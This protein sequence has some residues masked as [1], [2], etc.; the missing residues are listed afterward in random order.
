MTFFTSKRLVTAAFVLLVL[1]NTALLSILWQQ[2]NHRTET[3]HGV[4]QFD[5][6]HFF[7]GKLGLSELQSASFQKLR[8]QH[9]LKVRPEI[10]A[11]ALLKKQ[12]VEESLK[13][14]PDSK[15][16][17]SIIEGIGLHQ[18]AIER[19][20][21]LHFN[22][23]AKLCKPEQRKRLKDVLENMAAHRSHGGRGRWGEG[24]PLSRGECNRPPAGNAQN[25]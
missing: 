23:L 19:Q 2:N 8:Q 9:F 10:D 11:V 14:N 24:A 16:T 21:V 25:R 6:D 22:Q 5:H 7:A 15:T 20:L 17:E 13:D 18:A 4:R 12:L 1:L 3:T